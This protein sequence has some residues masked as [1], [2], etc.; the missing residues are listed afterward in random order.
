MR[1]A[2]WTPAV[3]GVDGWLQSKGIQDTSSESLI[4]LAGLPESTRVECDRVVPVGKPVGEAALCRRQ[5]KESMWVLA[6][7]FLLL[8]PENGRLQK[9]WEVPAAAGQLSRRDVSETPLVQLN[10]SMQDDGMLL[11]LEEAEGVGCGDWRARL[12]AARK[13]ADPEEKDTFTSLE[14]LA[15]RVCQGK[16][17]YAWRGTTF[18]R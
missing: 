14:R 18:R 13:D 3:D 7:S 4:K 17:R 16:G 15:A 6:T 11:F 12:A 9:V 2:D 5:Y 1:H 8:V 10:V